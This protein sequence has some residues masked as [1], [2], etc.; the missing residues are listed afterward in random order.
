MSRRREVVA[1]PLRG[2]D[3]RAACQRLF[4]SPHTLQ[5]H[6]KSVFDKLQIHSRRELR[7]IFNA[8]P[9]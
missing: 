4:I 3:T 2:L 7:A 5:D 1:V 8:A 6:V 9:S